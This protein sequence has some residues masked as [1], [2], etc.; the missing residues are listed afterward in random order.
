MSMCK[1][2]SLR[3][4]S[5]SA[6]ARRQPQR[7][8][9][10]PTPMIPSPRIPSQTCWAEVGQRRRRSP[11]P[12]SCASA[13]FHVVSAVRASRMTSSNSTPKTTEARRSEGFF[14]PLQFCAG[15]C[16]QRCSSVPL[17][18]LSF[19]LLL[20]LRRRDSTIRSARVCL[21]CE[22]KMYSTVQSGRGRSYM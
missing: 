8:R 14:S 22:K 19:S 21:E 12:R 9:R 6:A 1:N 13:L 3:D 4:L 2:P 5:R 10:R 15:R 20:R 11:E 18:R 17:L 16:Q 7:R